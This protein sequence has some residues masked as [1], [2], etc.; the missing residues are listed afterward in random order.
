MGVVYR[1]RDRVSGGSVAVKVISG[2]DAR[3]RDRFRRETRVLAS[4]AHPAIVR[5]V[6]DGET[7]DGQLFLAMEWLDG[8]TLAERL[9][10]GAL[11]LE[12]ARRVALR[13]AQAL[14]AAHAAGVV[15]R[16]V[17]PSNIYL[18][19]GDPGRAVLLDFGIAQV[20]AATHALTAAG[21][22]VGT[23]AYMAPEQC[24]GN[25]IDER[26]DLFALGC[27][28]YEAISGA[29]AFGAPTSHAIMAKVLFVTPESL[30]DRFGA[31]EALAALVARLLIKDPIARPASAALVASE[32]EA[33]QLPSM[34]TAKARQRGLT[35]EEK[36]LAAVVFARHLG[37]SDETATR[38]TA[39]LG[40]GGP[41]G[42]ETAIAANAERYG[43][44][45]EWLRDGS[46]VAILTGSG[47]AH[48]LAASAARF[49]LDLHRA[50]PSSPVALV[51][52]R[53]ELR[54]GSPPIGA[55]IDDAAQLLG[56]AP[57]GRISVDATT[58][59]L[60]ETRF[61]I[62]D[63]VEL[64][65][66]RGIEAPRLLIGRP[67]PCVGR[68][69]ELAMLG[70]VL[71]DCIAD[72]SARLVLIEAP[73]GT[74]KTRLVGE[75]LAHAARD[76]LAV[77][78]W[79]GA[80]DPISAGAPFAQVARLVRDALGIVDEEPVEARLAR[81]AQRVARVVPEVDQ[82]R[83]AVFLAELIGLSQADTP[84]LELERAR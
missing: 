61:M 41:A 15:H 68:D 57:A 20:A 6:A 19:H 44:R 21:A 69:D 36:Q 2:A 13:L 74:G 27:V 5:F 26:S 82:R 4:L 37:L 60:L 38:S 78:A 84:A 48:D 35:A 40:P 77:A 46:V 51:S 54:L 12:D 22:V 23:P 33:M 49:A 25:A 14:A 52:R 55:S 81:I 58:A 83:V 75:F 80:A 72:S 45:L 65:A 43:A 28:L 18:V 11:S 71:A 17:K 70:G 29:Q 7:A 47:A 8:E 64:R 62:I 73:A 59:A 34:A 67:S 53:V 63:G 66:E 30:R 1:A 32:L 79:R 9:L 10:R 39:V 24:R 31:P 50:M 16:D 56:A 3:A 76:G 42:I